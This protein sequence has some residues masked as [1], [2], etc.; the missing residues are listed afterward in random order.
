MGYVKFL[1]LLLA[2]MFIAACSPAQPPPPPANTVFD[3]LTQQID[4]AREVQKTVDEQ[5]E[6]TRKAL[7]NQERG[8]TPQ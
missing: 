7:E 5:A 1:T 3:P 6:K 2:V 4:R 8:D